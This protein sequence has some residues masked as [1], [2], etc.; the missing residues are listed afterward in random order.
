MNSEEFEETKAEINLEINTTIGEIEEEMG[1]S[2]QHSEILNFMMRSVVNE[3]K[4]HTVS[5]TENHKALGL[6]TIGEDNEDESSSS[7]EDDEEDD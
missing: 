1:D 2:L 4:R 5:L 3:V 6:E 7:N